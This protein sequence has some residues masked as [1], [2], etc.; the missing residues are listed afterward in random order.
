M[1]KRFISNNLEINM[2][3]FPLYDEIVSK[4][5]GTETPLTRSHCTTI[6]RLSQEHLNIIY[7]IILHHYQQHK[8]G[9]DDLPY[10]CRTVSNGKGISFRRLNQVPEEVQKIVHRYLILAQ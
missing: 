3:L 10:G 7:L 9:K 6:N 2:S 5:D 4:M 8:Q 1:N